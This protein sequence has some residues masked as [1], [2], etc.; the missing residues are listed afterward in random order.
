MLG[1]NS[2][3][4]IKKMSS[5][6][7]AQSFETNWDFAFTICVKHADMQLICSFLSVEKHAH[8]PRVVYCAI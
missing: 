6:R 2:Q 7:D 5:I 1:R 8:P 3:L 4:R